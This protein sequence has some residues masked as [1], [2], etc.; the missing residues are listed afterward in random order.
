MAPG[1]VTYVRDAFVDGHGFMRGAM[2]G[3]MLGTITVLD[4]PSTPELDAAALHRYLAEAVWLPTALLPSHGVE[5]SPL[6]DTSA[7]ARLSA[8]GITVTLDFRF[9]RDGL[10]ASVFTPTRFRDMDGSNVPTPWE[11]RFTRYEERGGMRIPV[12]AEVAWLLPDGRLTYW[13]GVPME[14]H[15]TQAEL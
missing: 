2:L 13:R 7:R 10:V 12:E 4:A 1:I 14:I 3:A 9:G 8:G 15:Y 5:W 11:G 6:T